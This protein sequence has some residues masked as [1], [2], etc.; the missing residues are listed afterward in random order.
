MDLPDSSTFQRPDGKYIDVGYRYQQFTILFIPVWNYNE[1]WCG[2][3]GSDKEYID[4][5]KGA[6]SEFAGTAGLKLP[7]NPSL[8]LWDSVGGKLL[9]GLILTLLHS[10]K[11]LSSADKKEVAVKSQGVRKGCVKKSV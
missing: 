8:P 7:D 1:K 6:L 5:D 10:K 4:F 3:I 2:Y 11:I 9:F